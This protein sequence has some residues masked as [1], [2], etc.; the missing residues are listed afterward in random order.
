MKKYEKLIELNHNEIPAIINVET[1]EIKQLESKKNNIPSGKEV[2]E[3]TAL[4][5][6]DYL[7]TWSF[8]KRELTPLEYTSAHT[9]ALMAKANTNSL[10]PLNDET[11]L[12]ELMEIL[13]VSINKVK[14]ILKKLWLY[15]VY[16]KFEV[17]EVG[18]LYTKYWIL[19]PYL[20]FSGKLIESDIAD[21]FK[22]THCAK[23]FYS[24]NYRYK[25]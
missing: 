7:K 16:G 20:S 14:P 23:A 18:K 13:N 15:G 12:K 3:P 4:F 21:L 24:E 2:F 17:A 9:L 1:G 25:R 8:L 11:T 5:K 19:N 22:N 10:E 6:K